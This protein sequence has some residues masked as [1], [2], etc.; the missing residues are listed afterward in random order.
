MQRAFSKP[1]QGHRGEYDR[2]LIRTR[3]LSKAQAVKVYLT[4]AEAGKEPETTEAIMSEGMDYHGFITEL[5]EELLEE[6]WREV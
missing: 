4:N 2:F 3:W 6:G 1:S 5:T